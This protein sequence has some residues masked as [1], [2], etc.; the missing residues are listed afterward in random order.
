MTILGFHGV[1]PLALL[2]FPMALF[3]ALIGPYRVFRLRGSLPGWLSWSYLGMLALLVL[4]CCL[5]LPSVRRNYNLAL[6]S[7]AGILVAVGGLAL[8]LEVA[9]WAVRRTRARPAAVDPTRRAVLAGSALLLAVPFGAMAASERVNVGARVAKRHIRLARA[10]GAAPGRP[11]KVSF[12][13]DLHAGFFLPQDYMA[14]ALRHVET[15][16]PD[17]VLFG[18]DL[19]DMELSGLT[20]TRSFLR[21]LSGVAPVYSVLGNHDCYRNAGEVAAFQADCGVTVLRGQGVNLAGSFGRFA[22]CGARDYMERERPDKALGSRESLASTLF[23]AH[24]P[25]TPLALD[26]WRTPWLSLCG[27]THGGQIRLPGV[28]SLVNQADRR[29]EPGVNALDGKNVLITAGIGFAGLPVRLLCPPEVVSLT[30]A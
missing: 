21:A 29:L 19:I 25:A 1:H 30:I 22:L 9:I 5:G 13:S 2:V 11:L 17:V 10:P 18:G 23:L 12:L 3:L 14:Q 20:Q 27:H 8:A 7:Y 4:T 26:S 6:M 16:G 24:N 28:G 15:F